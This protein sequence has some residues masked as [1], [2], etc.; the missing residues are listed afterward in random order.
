MFESWVADLLSRY[1]GKYIKNINTEQ[2]R[3]S[4]WAGNVELDHLE[5]KRE[6]LSELRLPIAV[7]RGI[8]FFK[9]QTG[10]LFTLI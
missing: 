9:N 4:V 1:L 3:I 6:A 2:L 7:K 8:N 10:Y 5:L